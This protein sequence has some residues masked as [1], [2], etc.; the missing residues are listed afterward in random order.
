MRL[1]WLVV[2][3]LSS[4]TGD[5]D[6]SKPGDDSGDPTDD[7]G[8]DD[9]GADDSG[10]D[11]SGTASTAICTEPTEV[12]CQDELVL[13]L[14]LHEE[15]TEGKVTTTVDG[16]DFLTLV[17][18]TAGG[19]NSASQNPWVYVKFSDAGATRVDIGDE[20]ALGSMDWDL[21]VR[22]FVLRLNGGSSGPSCV[23]AAADHSK[24]Y[25][26]ITKVPAGISYGLDDY[27]TE[28]CS[29]VNDTSGLEGSPQV[30]LGPWWEYPGCVA[31]TGTP[32][33]VQLADGH[34]LKL[35]VE[36]YYETDQETCNEKGMAVA[37]GGWILLRWRMLD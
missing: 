13:N 37:D 21:S 20:T 6:D 24:S 32:F 4:C 15:V 30:V 14:S 1:D 26:E 36:S 23:G 35:R 27:M 28:D 12:P 5:K 3:T 11:D 29:F 16:D 33:Y 7:S 8:T 9:S 31:T 18:A 17:D 2:L 19:F 25:E 10:T 22:R 34:V